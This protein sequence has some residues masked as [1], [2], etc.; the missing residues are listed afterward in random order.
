MISSRPSQLG[1]VSPLK[2][3]EKFAALP[4][5]PEKVTWLLQRTGSTQVSP[6]SGSKAPVTVSQAHLWG[7]WGSERGGVITGKVVGGP[8]LTQVDAHRPS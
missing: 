3:L 1:L 2:C 4:L 8:V 6:W 7:G 5:D